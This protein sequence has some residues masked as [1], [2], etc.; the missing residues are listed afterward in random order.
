MIISEEKK[1]KLK[2][3]MSAVRHT[4]YEAYVDHMITVRELQE[5]IAEQT[6]K[7][8][9]DYMNVYMYA[10]AL[11]GRNKHEMEEFTEKRAKPLQAAIRNIVKAG[12][13]E[14]ELKNYVRAKHGLERNEYMR[15]QQLR[16]V[17]EKIE[18][19]SLRDTLLSEIDGKRFS[20]I[21]SLSV[22]TYNDLYNNLAEKDFSGLTAIQEELGDVSIEEFIKDTE[23]TYGR[24]TDELWRRIRAVNDFSLRKWYDSGMIS[25][26]AY[27]KISGMYQYYVPLRGFDELEAH[28]VY[29]YYTQPDSA[30]NDPLKTARGRT[31]K[32]DDPFPHM[33][34]MAETAIVGGNKNM[35]KL[36]LYRL[37]QIDPS[38]IMTVS[39]QW[40]VK[41]GEDMNGESVFEIKYPE[42]DDNPEQYRKN[43]EAFNAEML[44][45]ESEGLAFTKRSRLN[46]GYRISKG[47]ANE[48]VVSL[49][50]NGEDYQVLFHGSPRAAQAINGLNQVRSDNPFWKK[51]E[52]MNRQ[53]A[54]NYTTRNPAFVLSNLARDTLYATASLTVKEGRVYRNRFIRNIPKAS[55][56]LIRR[57]REKPDMSNPVDVM[58]QEFIENGGQTGYTAL[59]GVEKY[60]KE[61]KNS[62]KTGMWKNTKDK[63]NFVKDIAQLPNQWAEDL[64]RF[65]TYMASRQEGRSIL[66]SVN[67][68][69]EVTLNFNTQGSGAYGNFYARKLFLFFN[70]AVQGLRNFSGLAIK[71]PFAV[72]KLVMKYAAVGYIQ[73]YISELI[74]SLLGDD[75]DRDAYNNL[76]DYV[77]KNNFCIP[78]PGTGGFLKIPLPIELRAFYGLGDTAYRVITGKDELREGL[79]NVFFGFADLLPLNP[80]GGSSKFTPASIKPVW[81]AYISNEDFTG[82]PIAKITPF[83][84]YDPEYQRVYRSTSVVPVKVSQF[85]NH[86]SR[87]ED[88][89]RGSIE[90]NPAKLEHLYEG[91][92]G[93]MFTTANQ[94]FK[95]LI[96]APLGLNEFQWRGVPV[97][98]RFFDTGEVDGTMMK[99]NEKYFKYLDEM[100]E[101]KYILREYKKATDE[102]T[103][104]DSKRAIEFE[105]SDRMR[106]AGYIEE[107]SSLVEDLSEEAEET[108]DKA[109]K[110]DIQDEINLIKK[111]MVEA[112]KNGKA[113]EE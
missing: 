99:V 11:P 64:S 29:E 107:K 41:T 43:I 95:T 83:N 30:Y 60:R 103:W 4:L 112:L 93:G 21:G 79:A 71:A 15:M 50:L 90:I 13:R 24:L 37:A 39:R 55:G 76:P 59:Y 102:G 70:A 62:L 2:S 3:K 94:T 18:D 35:M 58:L 106:R 5:R 100:R 73:P 104:E 16:R 49:R 87:S 56:A 45:L 36:Y 54:A 12:L 38:G 109:I 27:E 51:V 34:S 85:L 57:L 63:L 26:A 10:N 19:E 52:W 25:R 84:E 101:S 108:D 14:E 75:E 69:K 47:E 97:L 42:Y 32:S 31:S 20:E 92:L 82:K 68:A 48:H 86:I 1:Q 40:H 22:E 66:R 77:R 53:M 96:G 80:V 72:A 28:D 23:D 98:N 113:P 8:I 7:A 89:G 44:R 111:E 74:I 17:I 33:L 6:G 88:V 110:E 91:Y 65:S 78:L 105:N 46:T 81:E 9:P 67:D 61:L